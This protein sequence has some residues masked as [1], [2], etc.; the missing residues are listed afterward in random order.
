MEA[1]WVG[2]TSHG[3]LGLGATGE[4]VPYAEPGSCNRLSRDLVS[5][6]GGPVEELR[7]FHS[8]VRLYLTALRNATQR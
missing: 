3:W 8:P 5:C 7:F 2:D 6:A 1:I 4:V